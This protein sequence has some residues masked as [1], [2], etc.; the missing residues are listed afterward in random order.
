[1]LMFGICVAAAFVLAA[2]Y[3]GYEMGWHHTI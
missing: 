2:W 1:M 3:I